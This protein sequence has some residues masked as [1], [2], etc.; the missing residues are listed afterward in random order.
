MADERK[1][2]RSPARAQRAVS[3]AGPA[4]QQGGA[5]VPPRTPKQPPRKT[6]KKRRSRAVLAPLQ[7]CRGAKFFTKST[8]SPGLYFL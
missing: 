2:Y 7:F 3:G 6:S 5:G 8:V 4:R 1:V